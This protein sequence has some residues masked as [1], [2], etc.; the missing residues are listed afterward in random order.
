MLARLNSTVTCFGNRFDAIVQLFLRAKAIRCSV[1]GGSVV[2]RLA[3]MA[4]SQSAGVNAMR[5]VFTIVP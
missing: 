1:S 3:S 2:A 5:N 4:S